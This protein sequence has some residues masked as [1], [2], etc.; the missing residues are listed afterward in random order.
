MRMRVIFHDDGTYEQTHAEVGCEYVWTPK[1]LAA[2]VEAYVDKL[3]AAE[4]ND[5]AVALRR[6]HE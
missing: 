5:R 6:F 2:E 3:R 4:E 1:H